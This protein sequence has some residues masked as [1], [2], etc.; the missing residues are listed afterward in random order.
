MIRL[1]KKFSVLLALC[2]SVQAVGSI[3]TTVSKF[4]T[5]V[6]AAESQEQTI[7]SSKMSV[8][9][10]DKFPRV[11]Q[12]EWLANNAVMYGQ[13]DALNEV[14]IN[15]TSYT[16]TVTFNKTGSKASYTLSISSIDVT[17]SIDLEVV[18]NVLNYNVT[19]ITE[20]GTT[21]V[22]TFEIPNHNLLSVRSTQTG[23]AFAGTRHHTAVAGTGDTFL[24]V[25]GTPAV[26]SSPGNYMYSILNTN[27]LAGAVSTNA[28]QDY[29]T[30][31]D[32]DR[33]R[34]QTVNKT[35]YF[36]TGVW[37][38]PWVYRPEGM[39]TTEPLPSEKV[40]ITPDAN[41]D[42][43]IDWQDG[44]VAFRS[45]MKTPFG[46]ERIPDLV[47][48]RIPF[49]FASQAT[50][51]F[52]KTLD[53][54]KRISLNTDGLQQ[55]IELKG[56]QQEGHDSAHADYGNNIGIRQGADAD[57]N[58]LVDEGHKYGGYFG[59]HISATGANPQAKYFSENLVDPNKPGW[60]WLDLSFDY[61]KAQMRSEAATGAR[62]SRLQ[63][64]KDRVP[65]LD[66]IYNDAWFDQGWNGRRLAQEQNGLGWAT[67][68]E[69]PFVMEDDALWYHWSVD[70]NYGG[71]EIKGFN[72][73]IARFIRNHQKDTWIVRN[74]L[75]GGTELE[76]YE[77]WQGKVNYDDMI[78]M[79]FTTNLPT[80]YMQHF[81]ILK[82]T[83]NTID[84]TDNV[85]VSNVTGT[86]V[87]KKDGITILNGG[88]YLLPWSPDTED[89]LY[90]WNAGGGSTTW[91]L[92]LSWSDRQ[93]VKLYKL[94]DQGK[95]FIQDLTVTGNDV[96]IDA[97]ANTP[98]V[99]Y[100]GTGS[101][102]P[103]VKFGEG[104]PLK[105]PGFNSGNLSS[106]TV[107]GDTQAASVQRNT[108]GQYELKI[109]SGDSVSVSQ[110]LTGLSPGTYSAYVYVQVDGTRRARIGVKDYG[111]T[112]VSNYADSSFA[113]NGIGG[114]SKNGT[115]MQRMR[116]LFDVPAGQTTAMLYLQGEPGTANITLDDVHLM[117]IQR[118]AN[119]TGAYFAED[120]EHVDAGWYP[121]VKG[122][123][124][125][126]TVDP[127]TS[128]ANLHAP[129]TQK[130][131][132]GNPIDHVISGDWSL[133]S[134]KENMGL[135]YRTLPQTLRFAPGTNYTISF[136]YVNQQAGD[137]ALVIGDGTREISSVNFDTVI[138]T[139]TLTKV[140]A[141]SPSGNTW[142][143]IRKLNNNSSD[144]VMDDFTVQVG[145]VIPPPSVPQAQM[146]ATATSQETAGENTP[147]S[148]V[149]DGKSGTIWHTKWDSSNSLP[150]SITLNLGGT[151][152][153]TNLKYLPRQD[154]NV[155]GIITSY[156]VFV[157]HDGTNF[158]KVADGSWANDTT[159]K[160]AAFAST[161]ASYVK[162]EATAGNGGFAS[163]AEINVNYEEPVIIPH[164]QMTVTATSQETANENNS[165]S[166]ALD[167][168]SST[169]W[170]TNWSS[171]TLPQ[172]ITLNLGGSY[173]ISQLNY[174]PRQDG[175]S[176]GIITS[177]DI[178]TSADG[179]NFTKAATG[180]WAQ[181][182]A[183]KSVTFKP[184]TATHV[185]LVAV[186]GVNNFA[187]AAEITVFKQ[188]EVVTPNAAS[189]TLSATGTVQT[190]VE[191]PVQLGIGGVTQSVYAQDIKM[192]Y[193]ANVLEFVSAH[194]V[195]DG[196]DL[197]ETVKDTLGKLRFIIASL[198]KA[199]TGDVGILELKFKA[200]AVT[201]SA[202]GKIAVTDATLG[203]EHGVETKVQASAVNVRIGTPPPGVP[204]DFN[205]D[206]RVSIG[207]LGMV[208]VNY[209]KSKKTLS[210]TDWEKIKFAD[211]TGDGEIDIHDLAFVATKIM[212]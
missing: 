2:M 154:G 65:N 124:G 11:L 131:W 159:E 109:A 181:S 56:Y 3:Q 22:S 84:F 64:L 53:E 198:G 92:P 104:T 188:N 183:Q 211:V 155:N 79:T 175:Q 210:S 134:H 71:Q 163:A 76:S 15:G 43:G 207:D 150:Q 95:Q 184:V 197:V 63:E 165:A 160:N 116:V 202:T 67:T 120:F 176:N 140:I 40:V 126:T 114:D 122:D 83:N 17:I 156:N 50:N 6:V 99:V 187:S 70:Y 26:D 52:L 58:T 149:L 101:V 88:S 75:L 33:L 151:Y 147:A 60:D 105:D 21:K 199:V 20:S 148:N 46:S 7:G 167:G 145:G 185:K 127:R 55:F 144:F 117:K 44:A 93:S 10:D 38:A 68:T 190:G 113:I 115:K 118:S 133:M 179:V 112:E 180:N 161:S 85:S 61:N 125:G 173:P 1:V 201:E 209:G 102:T 143:G 204:G 164:E 73:Q 27:Q 139:Q 51:P 48:Q 90:H 89:K 98:Y 8:T 42:G 9:V 177:Y 81:P 172:S 16:P 158:T 137:Y 170:H 106:W 171:N 66:F 5:P 103:D 138:S 194:A 18:E 168:D 31:N 212:E 86:R 108:R 74:P 208:A 96:T 205:Q 157:S 29:T 59:V 62:L 130:G 34:K 128:L 39:S 141:G 123:A 186:Q 196:I 24:N 178:Y 174:L 193:D 35:G 97:L 119:P 13:E 45:I 25:T 162:L 206:N 41:G 142:V 191:F 30:D 192:D 111:G 49:N 91:T 87:I 107:S 195:K 166:N 57:I 152:N 94:T 14:K 12:Y 146:T 23:A 121:F 132:N 169:F 203:D 136:K 47:V 69:F 72:S 36:R 110:Q 200:K 28:V 80:K 78:K 153:V 82:W 4:T 54:T 77:G 189:A 100:K 135:L 19:G 182:A 129:Y 37:S 32:N